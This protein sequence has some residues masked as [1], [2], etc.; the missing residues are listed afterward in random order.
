MSALFPP[1]SNTVFRVIA[2]SLLAIPVIAVGAAY[3]YLESPY[4]TGQYDQVEQVI[5]FDHR[6]HVSDDG[7]DCR[8]CHGAVDHSPYAGVPS[9]SRSTR[10]NSSHSSIS[11][12]VF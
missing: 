7:I 4:Y 2:S 3:V 5:Q 8:Y 9:T 12:A 6:H 10:L 1:S 11:Y